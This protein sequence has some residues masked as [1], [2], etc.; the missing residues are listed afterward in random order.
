MPNLLLDPASKKELSW[1]QQM[2]IDHHY[3]HAAVDPRCRPFAY[4]L[5]YHNEPVGCLIFGRPQSTRCYVGKLTYGSFDDVRTGLALFDRWEVLN[6][7]RVWLDPRIQKFGA[8]YIPRAASMVIRI[9][10]QRI[11]FDY[12]QFAPPVDCAFPYQIKVIMSYCDT[13]IHN[14]WIYKASRFKHARIN[15]EGIETYYKKIPG[16]SLEQDEVI[17]RLAKN[18]ERSRRIRAQRDANANQIHMFFQ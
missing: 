4:I 8:N 14:G 7:A 15:S 13:R 12:L 2:V 5:R 1:A 18:N 11:G 3:L 10:L 9:A 16:L 17:R 6:L